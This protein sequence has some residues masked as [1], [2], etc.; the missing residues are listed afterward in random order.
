MLIRL[1]FLVALVF[2]WIVPGAAAAADVA[3][4][5]GLLWKVE[6][7]GTPP[8]FVFGTIHSEDPRVTRLPAPVQAAFDRAHSLTVEMLLGPEANTALASAMFLGKDQNLR[9]ILGDDLY[10]RTIRALEE[11]GMPRQIA[12]ALKPWAVTVMLSMPKPDTGEFLDKVLYAAA[13]DQ[14][15]PVHGLESVEEQLAIFEELPMV[16]QVRLLEAAMEGSPAAHIEQLIAAYLARDLAAM[17]MLSNRANAQLDQELATR[18][19]RRL[20]DD[21]N[22]RMVQ[23][24][25]PRLREGNAFIA[26][27]ALHLPGE[28]GILKLLERRG[29]RVTVVY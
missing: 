16:D 26:V 8:S 5:K 21:R 11:Y 14:G 23:R 15:K 7:A 2:G 17:V 19:T 1:L 18:I 22:E 12:G 9:A 25:E 6:R 28:R 3:H 10:H 27:G 29:Y 20:L 4:E 13:L 24:M